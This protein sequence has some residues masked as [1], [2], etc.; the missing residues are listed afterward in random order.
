MAKVY[1]KTD[2]NSVITEIN[3]DVFLDSIE[4]FIMIDE[5][6]GDKYAH[7]QG[8]YLE[9]GL[10][11]D[12]GRYNYKLQDGNSIE[13]TESEKEELFP[14]PEPTPSDTEILGQMATDAEIE[15]MELGQ[16][17]TD[18]ELMILEGGVLNA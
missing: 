17:M 16:R 6:N 2:S 10:M 7:A 1:V 9:H 14:V 4:G 11:D 8:N 15:R 5:G 12:K 18:I 13:L 3:S